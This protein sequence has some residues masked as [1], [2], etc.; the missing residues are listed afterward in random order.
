MLLRPSASFAVC[1][2]PIQHGKVLAFVATLRLPFWLVL[3]VTLGVTQLS[4]QTP[5]TGPLRSIYTQLDAPLAQALSTWIV[6]MVPIGMPLLYFVS[7]L[8]AH[9]GVALT[10]G[11]PRSIGAS[12]RAVGYAMAPPLLVIGALDVPLYLGELDGLAGSW[13]YLGIVAWTGLLFLWIAMFSLA[14]THQMSVARG[15]LVGL[16]PALLIV[17][18]TAGRASLQLTQLPFFPELSSEYY[19]P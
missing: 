5:Q 4:A 11:A 3:L 8:V 1:P 12:M 9:V 13:A 18:A 2:E 17:G 19:V 16:L 14:R 6:L 10:G 15:F 7:G